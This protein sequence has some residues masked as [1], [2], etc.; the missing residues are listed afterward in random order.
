MVL[1]RFYNVSQQFLEQN[2]EIIGALLLSTTMTLHAPAET[3][4]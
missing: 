2:F 4:T 3:T 1:L